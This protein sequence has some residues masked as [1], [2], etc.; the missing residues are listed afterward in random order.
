MAEDANTS[1]QTV[2]H[3]RT[4]DGCLT[5]RLRRK[6]RRTPRE[7]TWINFSLK[8]RCT[9]PGATPSDACADCKERRLECLGY[10]ER[11]PEWMKDEDTVEACKKAMTDHINDLRQGLTDGSLSLEEFYGDELPP[12]KLA[13]TMVPSNAPPT[14]AAE[15][16]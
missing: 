10:S 9:S 12:L 16:S 7:G 8:Q 14:N 13:R 15:G 5:C 6:V 4:R 11:R 3:R 1:A 2:L